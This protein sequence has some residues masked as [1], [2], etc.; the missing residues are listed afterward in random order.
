[1]V[2][3]G[4]TITT[5]GGNTIHTFTASGEWS[6]TGPSVGG[7]DSFTKL[8]LHADGVAGSNVVTDSSASN[9]V[10]TAGGSGTLA[11]DFVKFGTASLGFNGVANCYYGASAISADYAFGTA[12]FTVE[13]W[14]RV[15]GWQGSN[16]QILID[17]GGAPNIIVYVDPAGT[18]SLWNAGGGKLIQGTTVLTLGKWF[19]MAVARA[20]AVTRLFLN[21]MQEGPSYADTNNYTALAF[22]PVMGISSVNYSSYPL[23]GRMDEVRISKG[24][25]RYTANFT[26][27]TGPFG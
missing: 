4:G 14:F 12:D 2:A 26:P 20:A 13:L 23:F 1:M 5:A 11:T 8:L 21:G 3:A 24:I 27:P 25:A 15:Q 16:Y 18:I 19:H 10:M 9:H 6:V 7:N 17:L 22:A